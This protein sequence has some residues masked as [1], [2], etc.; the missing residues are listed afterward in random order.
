MREQPIDQETFDTLRLT[1][2]PGLGP[3]RIRQLVDAFGGAG[4]ALRATRGAI[5][6][7]PGFG[8]S[9]AARAVA[10]M[11]ASGRPAERELKEAAA[12]DVT[13]VA[14][15][16]DAY[17]PL[18]ALIHDPPTLLYVRGEIDPSAAD[19]YPVALVGSRACTTYGRE[20]AHRFG[21][22]LAGAGLTV[23]SGGARGIDTAAHRGALAGQGRT[24]AVLGCGLSHIY[25]PDNGELFDAIVDGGGALISEL[26]L[27]R[28]PAPEHFPARNR[29][30][31]GLSLGTLVIEAGSRSGAIITARLAGEQGREVFALP[32]RVDSRHSTGSLQL[33]RDGVTPAIEPG[34]VV[35][36]LESVARHQ[37]GGTLSTLAEARSGGVRNAGERADLFGV[38]DARPGLSETQRGIL[39]SL[40]EALTLDELSTRTGSDAASL[41][42]DLTVLEIHR[43]VRWA[44]T[45]VERL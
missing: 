37:F 18:L 41:R 21:Q 15:G 23:I 45:R 29:I 13:L 25:P 4:K 43:C 44:G 36:G 3:V 40:E 19:R 38:G 39:A 12:L 6:A 27:D 26:S 16:H 5:E 20:Q 7:L 14:R 17:P 31:A 2:T 33:I 34:D 30:I 22:A 32:G 10:G 42:A 1:M 24:V 8:P 35:A 9:G 11:R 28:H